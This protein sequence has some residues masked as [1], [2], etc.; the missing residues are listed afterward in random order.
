MSGKNSLNELMI[1]INRDKDSIFNLL[2]TLVEIESP[3]GD[4]DGLSRCA[5][6]ITDA[7]ADIDASIAT[8]ETAS[9]PIIKI[10]LT[11]LT[12]VPEK[13]LLI[14]AHMDTVYP[15]GTTKVFPFRSDGNT[16]WGPGIFDMKAGLVQAV[17]TLRYLSRCRQNLVSS[18]TLLCTPDEE[19]GSIGSKQIIEQEAASSSYVFITEPSSGEE[20]A[21]KTSRSGR[22]QYH[23]RIK[24]LSSHAGLEPQ[25]GVS[26]VKELASQIVQI[27][28]LAKADE[29]LHINVGL[30]RGGTAVNVIPDY[31]EAVVDVR[32]LHQSQMEFI[33][34]SFSALKPENQLITMSVEGGIERPPWEEE[35][36]GNALFT[37]AKKMGKTIGLTL[38]SVHA[39]GSGDG[40]F[41]AALGIPTLDGLGPKGS[42]AHSLGRETITFTSLLE[43]TALLFTLIEHIASE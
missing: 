7:F 37:L 16:L 33:E 15:K 9:G 31:A 28:K 1:D 4:I 26:A 22:A 10:Q 42:G 39:G 40:N 12:I 19:I 41:T 24:G 8:I 11:P 3:S 23:L 29:G 25:L 18:I 34:K 30:V 43:R 32:F 36:E 20:G 5:K 27:Y 38:T 35:P 21:L 13:N 17:F 2:K 14:L 6:V